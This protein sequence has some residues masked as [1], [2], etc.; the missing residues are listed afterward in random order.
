LYEELH[1][2]MENV[3]KTENKLIFVAHPIAVS[4]DQVQRELAQLNELVSNQDVNDDVV[5]QT[6]TE[7]VDGYNPNRGGNEDVS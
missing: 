2:E 1:L 3:S 7:V 4:V 5:I 6:L